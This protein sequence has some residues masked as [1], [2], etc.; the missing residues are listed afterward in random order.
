MK[1]LVILLPVLLALQVGV[2]PALAWTWPVDGP[3]LRPFIL[4]ADP[5]AAGPHRSP[6]RPAKRPRRP[7]R[8]LRP[9]RLRRRLRVST[10]WPT[11]LLP[12]HSPLRPLCGTPR[13][14]TGGERH[15]IRLSS[16]LRSSPP[17]QGAER[18]PT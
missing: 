17:G 14:T 2:Q 15:S 9:R 1:R 4:G 8:A 7:R 3:A 5:Y 12:P 6:P 10:R 13:S 18:R 11:L 16:G